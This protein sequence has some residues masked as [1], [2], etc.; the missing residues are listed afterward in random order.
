VKL[1]IAELSNTVACF[2]RRPPE[3]VEGSSLPASENLHN[4][5]NKP[6]G[7]IAAPPRSVSDLQVWGLW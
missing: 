1:S 6:F 4:S 5:G 3:R 2:R 7:S